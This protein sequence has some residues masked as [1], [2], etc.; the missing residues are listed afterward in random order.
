MY[1][2]FWRLQAKPFRPPVDGEPWISLEGH[3]AALNKLRYALE[4][5]FPLA[6]LSGPAGVGKT[7]LLSV[8][9]KK[10]SRRAGPWVTL[11]TCLPAETELLAWIADLLTE[12]PVGIQPTDISNSFRRISQRLTELQQLDLNAVL[13]LESAHLLVHRGG[14][15]AVRQLA[16]LQSGKPVLTIVLS[17][18]EWF[19]NALTDHPAL[20]Q[21]CG[22]KASL[23]PLTLQQ[24]SDY[25]RGQ[26]AFAAVQR[27]LFDAS[28][29]A[30]IYELSGGIPRLINRLA[31]LALLIGYAEN[32]QQL[33]AQH[34]QGVHEELLCGHS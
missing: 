2:A 15:E 5:S 28:A 3:T 31:D 14:L 13:V 12:Q 25:L 16:D 30:A 19:A 17:G 22:V 9:K 10:L 21:R 34:I 6:L 8:L 29:V 33:N 1:Q 20:E 24:T 4:E 7:H 18:D 26:L 23:P 32:A 27:E 11:P